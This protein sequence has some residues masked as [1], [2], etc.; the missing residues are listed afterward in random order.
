MKLKSKSYSAWGIFS[1]LSPLIVS[2]VVMATEDDIEPPAIPVANPAFMI[3]ESNFDQWIFQG[4]G[5]ATA[6]RA[7]INSHLK[8]KL[9]ELK[10]TC[11]LTELQRKKLA[12][13]AQ[14]DMKRFFD[15]VEVLRKKF[16]AVRNDQNAFNELWQEIHPLQ[17]KQQAGLFNENSMFQ[18]ALRSTL[19]E[20]QQQRYQ[21]VTDERRRFRYRASIQTS[22]VL[23][24]DTVALKD[25]QHKAIAKLLLEETALPLRFGQQDQQV[26]LYGLS[27]LPSAKLKAILTDRQWKLMQ[28]QLTQGQAMEQFLAQNGFID[29]PKGGGAKGIRNQINMAIGALRFEAAA[30]VE[31]VDVQMIEV[32]AQALPAVEAD[33]PADALKPERGTTERN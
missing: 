26:V 24:S 18:K 22:L 31:A 20:E 25:D 30:A 12:L 16:L 3:D 15:Q 32:Q 10:K 11:D 1:W 8:L 33:V 5:T 21:K 9:D 7:R 2:T 27:K 13:A 14:G 19:N 6:G 29:A 4:S 23:I 28:P 17:Q